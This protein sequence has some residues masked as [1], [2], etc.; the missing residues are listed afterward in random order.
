MLT[1]VAKRAKFKDK[2]MGLVE[3]TCSE[4]YRFAA[5]GGIQSLQDFAFR[6]AGFSGTTENEILSAGYSPRRDLPLD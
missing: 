2:G 3:D 4:F 1:A 5:V 6:A